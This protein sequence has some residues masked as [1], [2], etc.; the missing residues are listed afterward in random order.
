MFQSRRAS[1]GIWCR[2]SGRQAMTI[3]RQTDA[4]SRVSA[5]HFFL[6]RS[7]KQSAVARELIMSNRGQRF[8]GFVRERGSGRQLVIKIDGHQYARTV[9]TR[10]LRDAQRMLP[11][12]IAEVQSG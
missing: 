8:H 3:R 11:A 7:S 6:E 10:T 12:F 1:V 2:G 9:K 5:G 4:L